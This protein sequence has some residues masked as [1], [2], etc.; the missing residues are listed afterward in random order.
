VK[1][2]IVKINRE[3]QLVLGGDWPKWPPKMRKVLFMV[4]EFRKYC[5]ALLAGLLV[6]GGVAAIS[7]V[8]GSLA[9][10]PA[11]AASPPAWTAYVV[12]NATDAVIPVNTAT[13]A[14]ST[15]IAAG[16]G[17]SAIAITPDATTAYVTD[18]GTTNTSPGFVTPID[19]STNT[20]GTAIPVGSGPDAIA[21]TP[22]GQTAYVGNYNDDT[23][24][25]VDLV[26][27]AAGTPIPVGGAPTSIA[28]TPDGT[29]AYV[30]R[31]YESGIQLDLSTNSTQTGASPSGF[32]SAITPDGGTVVAT[33]PQDNS[34]EAFTTAT[35]TGSTVA[36]LNDPE[37]V[38]ITPDGSTAY[39]AYSPFT[40]N[41]GALLPI[42]LADTNAPGAPINLGT[43]SAYAVAI[44]PDGSTAFVTDLTGG[45]LVPVDLASGTAGTPI[46]LGSEGTNP[47]A[48]AITPD[49][50]PI[51]HVH[52][53]ILGNLTDSFDASASTVAYG[54]IASYAWNFGDGTTETTTTPTVTH[55]YANDNS[56]YV[57]SVTETSSAGTSTTEV[58]TGQTASETG[59][60]QATATVA[61]S[62]D[63]EDQEIYPTVTAVT[64]DIGSTYGPSTVTISG[65]GF[66]LG[67]PVVVEV[68]V[69]GIAA[70]NVT[71][72]SYSSITATL[73]AQ[74]AGVYNVIVETS[75]QSL[76]PP[77]YNGSSA[78]TPADQFTYSASAP[79]VDVSCT[80]PACAIPV[81]QYG[82][83][84]VSS[85]VSSG[86]N[87]CTYSASVAEGVPATGAGGGSCP[88]GMSYDQA[89]T[90][91]S[92]SD[93]G[94]TPL[95]VTVSEFDA[96]P[97]GTTV[98]AEA[99]ALSNGSDARSSG[100]GQNASPAGGLGQDILLKKCA[101]KAVAPCLEPVVVNGTTV[102]TTVILPVN[103][104]ITLTAG[105]QKDTIKK[106]SPK[107]GGAPG[108]DLTI[109]GTNLNQVSAVYIDGDPAGGQ[110]IGGVQASIVSETAKKLVV[111]VPSGASTGMVTLIGWSGDVTSSST[112]KVT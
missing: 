84:S 72:D 99:E 50:A 69:G 9:A 86:C 12:S 111:T 97:S 49:Q 71:V 108:S 79:P 64:P 68:Y 10:S 56:N 101:K 70:T 27:N 90:T 93:A 60:P 112:F 4:T 14:V 91:V 58:F 43:N 62:L 3:R 63:P 96:P 83:T 81:V 36:A 109:T 57:A 19:L 23:V 7:V 73:P 1:Q 24:T 21:I 18:E 26:T 42:P 94:T 98:C 35:D 67:Y 51:A 107:K 59:G 38:A 48:I 17:P 37:G 88:D 2:R 13:D 52:V 20:A 45:N 95:T 77:Q 16:S 30:G 6:F 66:S 87:P 54:T 82:S 5:R 103:E 40:T 11:A 100:S 105:P 46:S 28:I 74:P 85:T 78:A 76:T 80:S 47:I 41:K 110:L 8:G 104:S 32:S 61:V 31:A 102:E 53:N 106:L 25:P 29:T 75:F 65:S 34:V 33:S 55:A 89:Q 39:V 92:E 15:P 22:N 44:T